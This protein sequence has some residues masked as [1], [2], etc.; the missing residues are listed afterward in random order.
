MLRSPVQGRSILPI[1][2]WSRSRALLAG[3]KAWLSLAEA[4][5]RPYNSKRAIRPA[6]MLCPREETTVKV[7]L[8]KGLLVAALVVLPARASCRNAL[9][10]PT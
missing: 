9:A 4:A 8:V 5:A 7:Q 10:F 1:R 3:Q 6:I 2:K